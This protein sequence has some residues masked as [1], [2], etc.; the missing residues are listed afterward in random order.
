LAIAV[1]GAL[2]VVSP[3]CGDDEDVS[4]T[5]DNASTGV[6]QGGGGGAPPVYVLPRASKSGAIDV[7]PD[8]SLVAMVNPADDSMSVFTTADNTRLSKVPT[9]DEPSAVVIHPDGTTAFV[10]NRADATVVK[11]TGIDT[12]SPSVSDPIE[13]GSEPTGLALS[14]TGARLFVAEWAEGRVSVIDTAQMAIVDSIDTP[15]N[16]RALA[17]TN[18]GDEDESDERLIVPEFFGDRVDGGETSN[19][20]RTGLVRTYSLADL[21]E[22]ESITFA[23]LDS[24]FGEPTAMT[25]P[26]QLAAVAIAGGKIYV[27][28]ISASP[29]APIAFNNNVQPVVY[30]ASLES[31]S[32]D[33]SNV[34]TKNLAALVRDALPQ[35]ETRF[36]LADL[37]DVAMVGDNI[38][39]V[40]SK[41]SDV[42]QRVEYNTATGAQIGSTFNKQIE[43]GTAPAGAPAGCQV[44]IGIATN[45][46][47]K[48][49]YVNC[50]VSRRLGVIDLTMQQQTTTV[51]SF[52]PPQ[53]E[54]EIAVNRGQRFF[55]TGRG[56][57]SSEGWSSCGSC[58]PDGLTDNITWSFGAGPRQS[59]SL[60]GSFSK[61]SG[62]QLQRIFNWTGIFDEVHDFE[63]NTRGTSGGLGAITTST[64]C[65]TLTSET[66]SAVPGPPNGLLGQP[67]K[68]IQDT[69]AN[70]CTTDWN[71]IE[72]Y[73]RTIRAPRALRSVDADAVARG[74]QLF[75]DGGCAKC[76]GGS[77]W[78]VSRRFFTPSSTNNLNLLQASF[79]AQP[80]P[81]GFPGAWNEHSFEIALE[82]GTNIAPLQVA[83]AI[84]NVLT[85]GVPGDATAT[86]ALENKDS[87]AVAQGQKGYNVP[88]LYGLAVGAP[89]LHHGQAATLQELFSDAR[90]SEHLQAGNQVF[91]PDAADIDDLVAFLLSIDASAEEKPIV[92]GFDAC[93]NS[94]P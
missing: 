44:P 14:P 80:F 23:P 85:F 48:R 65:G 40:L 12:G 70:N 6:A 78:T 7:S 11:I 67:V 61:G 74:A 37:I 36:F 27:P 63:R 88:S 20:G 57:W 64:M 84:R 1:A 72:A 73:M 19:T 83:C 38:A 93:R 45:H 59:T 82:P 4:T 33:L 77:G 9:G 71:D 55:F 60:D 69:Q 92:A 29:A 94:F 90:W 50:W 47:G 52:N 75:D 68:E 2:G 34:G 15:R 28:S 16:P 42:V 39:Y 46:E 25:S 8:D 91:V 10:A 51:E 53:S 3:G 35:G 17:V 49:A 62:P 24:G 58:H 30:V 89:Y 41:G 32:E 21:S 31:N 76:H 66:A 87:G 5:A 13:V 79:P 56:R 26:N 22:G 81:N 54:E 18:S 43:I 86:D